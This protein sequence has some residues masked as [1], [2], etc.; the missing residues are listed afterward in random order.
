MV[1]L[2]HTHALVQSNLKIVDMKMKRKL[3]NTWVGTFNSVFF[4][5]GSSS[6]FRWHSSFI[7]SWYSA[8]QTWSRVTKHKR[9]SKLTFCCVVDHR[10]AT[11]WVSS[12]ND[13][14]L[15]SVTTNLSLDLRQL[16]PIRVRNH[17][18]FWVH[19]FFQLLWGHKYQ[20]STSLCL[21]TLRCYFIIAMKRHCVSIDP[22]VINFNL[23][24]LQTP[25]H[26]LAYCNNS[27]EPIFCVL[28]CC[29]AESDMQRVRAA[30]RV[31][32]GSKA[33]TR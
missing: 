2:T 1:T 9:H 21:R 16:K 26:I 19:K 25:S 8:S 7:R 12:V 29:M 11:L 30:Y 4:L 3:S 27:T 13:K 17:L 20:Q 24:S 33:A 14:W 6:Y 23:L 5:C 31:A 15:I 10:Q 18:P 28:L 22:N 32:G